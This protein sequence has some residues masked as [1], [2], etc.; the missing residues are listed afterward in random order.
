MS[1]RTLRAGFYRRALVLFVSLLAVGL[2]SVQFAGMSGGA[3]T[4]SMTDE[5]PHR[6]LRIVTFWEPI[7][8]H[9]KLY[10][11]STTAS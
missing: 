4:S 11:G 9:P 8:K 1:H 10:V 5:L 6:L 2:L 7:W 3:V